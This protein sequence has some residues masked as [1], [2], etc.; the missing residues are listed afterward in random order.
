MS[1]Q[2]DHPTRIALLDAGMRLAET[3]SLSHLSVNRIVQEAGVAK[4]TF[5]VHFPDRDSYLVA[6]HGRFHETLNTAIKAAIEGLPRGRENLQRGT[7]AY[8]DGCLRQRQLKA[9]L[10][11]ARVVPGVAMTVQQRNQL[12]YADVA[13]DLAT[14][15]WLEP[16]LAAR[17]FVTMVAEAAL[18]ELEQGQVLTAV[19][20]TLWQFLDSAPYN[21]INVGS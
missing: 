6:L 14:M 3:N 10:V 15:G 7:E 9:L 21:I 8:L 1:T 4:G 19:R 16:L 20:H 12:Y 5:Y 11:E 17:L 18:I 13:T 2:P